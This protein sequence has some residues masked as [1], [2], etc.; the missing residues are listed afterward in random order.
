[1]K[2]VFSLAAAALVAGV[3]AAPATAEEHVVKM[4]N[5][6]EAGAMVFE[7]AFVKAAPGDTV[8]FVPADKGHNAQSIHG[9]M[10]EGAEPFAGKLN[11]E[12][13]ITVG[14]AGVYGFECKPHAGLGMVGVIV[15]GDIEVTPAAAEG[16]RLKARAR[17]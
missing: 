15:A 11:E 8:R 2:L 6:G 17:R 3:I 9:M 12:V 1:M 4:L 10:P 5:R 14:E 7:P 13:V 16:A